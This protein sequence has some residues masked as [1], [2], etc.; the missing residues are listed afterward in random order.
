MMM[1][2]IDVVEVKGKRMVPVG[3]LIVT[4]MMMMMMISMIGTE[5]LRVEAVIGI[6]KIIV[7]RAAVFITE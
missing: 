1:M 4:K 7:L 2:V 5:G 3:Q 6:K